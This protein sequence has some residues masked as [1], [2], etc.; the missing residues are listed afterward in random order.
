[1]VKTKIPF[2]FRYALLYRYVYLCVYLCWVYGAL[3]RLRII[4]IFEKS[5]YN[6]YLLLFFLLKEHFF[7]QSTENVMQILTVY[8]KK[9][10]TQVSNY[11]YR[12]IL[13]EIRTFSLQIMD[14]L[15]ELFLYFYSETNDISFQVYTTYIIIFS[16]YKY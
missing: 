15:G 2:I 1:M 3:N 13:Y 9:R 11:L 14:P 5:V 6:K 7:V 8:L 16:V 10:K 4:K 12:F